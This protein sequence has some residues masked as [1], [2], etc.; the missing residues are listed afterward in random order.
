MSK[1]RSVRSYQREIKNLRAWVD[2]LQW[3]QPMYN[4]SPSCSGCGEQQHQHDDKACGLSRLIASWSA[5]RPVRD[6]RDQPG[7]K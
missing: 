6:A 7:V 2:E 4:G 3:V 5:A 1:R